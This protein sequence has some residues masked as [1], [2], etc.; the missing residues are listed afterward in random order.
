MLTS[1][2]V[3]LI[4]NAVGALV[5]YSKTASPDGFNVRLFPS[6]VFRL[7]YMQIIALFNQY[8]IHTTVKYD[9]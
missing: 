2:K 7:N 1:V 3:L 4:E 6:F 8:S 5:N 9:E